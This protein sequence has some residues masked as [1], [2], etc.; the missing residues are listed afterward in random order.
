MAEAAVLTGDHSRLLNIGRFGQ[1]DEGAARESPPAGIDVDLFRKTLKNCVR[2]AG[3]DTESRKSLEYRARLLRLADAIDIDAT[4]IP[5]AF[6]TFDRNRSINDNLENFKRQVVAEVSISQGRIQVRADATRPRS[7]YCWPETLTA[8]DGLEDPWSDANAERLEQV[9]EPL[10]RWLLE[11]WRARREGATVLVS[12]EQVGCA[13]ALA[14]AAE[15]SDKFNAVRNTPH[16]DHLE[17]GCFLWADRWETVR[18]RLTILD[19][20]PGGR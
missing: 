13:S 12:D 1:L 5:I 4:R 7:T 11:Y 10:G 17:L 6:L 15:V 8:I 9:R 18:P 3:P 20:S 16:R 19:G 2:E 14:V